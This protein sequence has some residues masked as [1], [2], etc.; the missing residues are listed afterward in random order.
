MDTTTRA[1]WLGEAQS[2]VSLSDTVGFIR[3]LPHKLVEAFEA[4]LHEAT[5]A[6]LLL[7]V[8][9]CASPLLAEQQAEVDRVLE[10]IDASA[11]P[12]ILVY[13]KADLLEASLRPR[14]ASDW[15]EVHPGVRCQRVWVSAATGEGLAEL[16]AAIAETALARLNDGARASPDTMAVGASALLTASPGADPTNATQP[17]IHA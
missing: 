6:D 9:D 3:D 12:Q 7:H 2:S 14:E 10:G 15:I 11:I 13:N 5:E 16:R 17:H 4:T 8:I 1:L